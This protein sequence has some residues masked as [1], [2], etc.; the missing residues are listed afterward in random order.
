LG[1]QNPIR[2]PLQNPIENP[3]RQNFFGSGKPEPALLLQSTVLRLGD[4]TSD[5][6]I[7]TAV[8]LPWF[9]IADRVMADSEFLGYYS[10]HWRE[11]EEFLAGVY[12]QHGFEE[13]ILTPRNNDIG[14]DVIATKHGIC[15]VR[16]LGQAK[17]YKPRHR[18]ELNDVNAMLG[19]LDGD[20]PAA[21]KAMLVTTSDF[22]P[23]VRES[24]I[25]KRALPHRLELINGQGLAA[26]LRELPARV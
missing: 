8:C 25:V 11:F 21:N 4:D 15:S 12:K 2:N 13:V 19:V 17:A 22:A 10:K 20:E 1:L 16:I 18:V 14:R 23:R 3:L 6:Q 7:V 26:W 24:P 5:G 9:A